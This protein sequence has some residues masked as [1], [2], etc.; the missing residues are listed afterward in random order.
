MILD[1]DSKISLLIIKISTSKQEGWDKAIK[2][3]N[4]WMK[5][6]GHKDRYMLY[7]DLFEIPEK[8]KEK[9]FELLNY[10]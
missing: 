1:L 3:I 7:S 9:I 8:S 10:K 2:F 6:N 4:D 5:E